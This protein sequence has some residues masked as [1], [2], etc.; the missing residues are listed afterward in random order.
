MSFRIP[1]AV[2]LI[3]IGLLAI[4][5]IFLKESPAWLLRQGREEQAYQNLEYLRMVPRDHIYI[6]EEVGFVKAKLED[7]LEMS[8]GRTGIK[9][10]LYGAFKELSIASMR[11]RL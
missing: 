11:H 9:G 2:Q 8:G 10:Y 3:P 4:G 5:S 6:Q 7:E 1:M